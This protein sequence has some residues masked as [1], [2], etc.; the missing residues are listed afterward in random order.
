MLL[1]IKNKNQ[2]PVEAPAFGGLVFC[3][4]KLEGFGK[5]FFSCKPTA[6][7]LLLRLLLQSRQA[8]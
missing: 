4:Y 6:F 2:S 1:I 7:C 5:A 8:R 3:K